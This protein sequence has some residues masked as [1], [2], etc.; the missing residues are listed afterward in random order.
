MKKFDPL[1]PK[2]VEAKRLR[3][4]GWT[5]EKIAKHLKM[6][7]GWASKVCRLSEAPKF[8]TKEDEDS[9]IV[10]Y[11]YHEPI[12]T[13][14]DACAR[15]SVDLKTWYVERWECSHWT[16]GMNVKG[17]GPVQKQQ[18]RVKIFLKRIMK[19]AIQE[20]VAAVYTEMKQHS[21]KYEKKR[22]KQA[23][24]ETL[25][26]MCLFDAH[27]GKL[28]WKPEVGHD[29]D[30]RI[31]EGMFRNAVDDLM[32]RCEHRTISKFC[33]PVGNDFFHIDNKQNTT[34]RG[35]PQDTDGRYAKIF[36]AGKLAVIWAIERMMQYADVDVIWV[37]GNH[38]PTMSYHLAETIDSWFHKSG[39]VSVDV[40]PPTRKYYRWNDTLL[41]L[42]HGDT[43]K[44][45]QL[46]NMMAVER[47]IDWSET[48]CR[49]WLLGHRH[50]SQQWTTKG[51]DS[52]TGTIV[53]TIQAL[54]ATDAWHYEN[55]YVNSQRAAEVLFYEKDFGY[56]GNL[57]AQARFE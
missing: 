10:E 49:E 5:I 13:L 52:H 33:M 28:A 30:L 26:V 19:R 7:H 23:G 32:S 6:S 9:S 42:T 38:D 29:Y 17:E 39:Q 15:A 31:A 46:P 40:T 41:G 53:R 51:T 36:K 14:E 56:A 20:A 44:P 11:D 35:T 16:V 48:K 55:G 24:V 50:R 54:T 57:I 45:E 2:V 34:L 37:P 27:F 22:F 18:Y 25:A 43:V 21:P 4:L 47:P 1:D 12:K 8:G 3:G